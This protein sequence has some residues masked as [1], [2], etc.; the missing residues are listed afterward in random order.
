VR[1]NDS[2]EMHMTSRYENAAGKDSPGGQAGNEVRP[3]GTE[4]S[5]ACRCKEAS[6]MTP[7]QLLDLMLNDLAFWKK[8]E[9]E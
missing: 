9:K 4:G 7:R 5:D 6:K 2:R 3:A 8:R 1:Y